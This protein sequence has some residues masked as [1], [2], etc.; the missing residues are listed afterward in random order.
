MSLGRQ[1]IATLGLFLGPALGLVVAVLLP[2]AAAGDQ[3]GLSSAGVATIAVAACMA[4]WWLTQALP[5]AATALLPVAAFPLLGI[6]DIGA[7]TA[8]Y[9]NPLI[10]LF[11]GGFLIGL[12][13]QR[14]G[15]H[16]RI[17]L[18]IL[19]LVGA[20]PR[21]LIGGFMLAAALLSMW[22]SNTAT[23]IMMLPIGASVLKLMEEHRGRGT[24]ASCTPAEMRAFGTA[25]ASGHCLRLLDRRPGDPGRHAPQPGAG[26]LRA[27]ALRPGCQ[28][29]RMAGNRAAAGGRAIAPGLVVPDPDR[30][31]RSRARPSPAAGR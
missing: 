22:I 19:L 20:G 7:S 13:I 29:V 31:R 2:P 11:L 21:A 9:A 24:G 6:A 12:A 3:P 8:P 5:L 4:T 26:R 27:R 18:H 23:A 15:L 14:F 16:R 1:R 28:H 17:A 10:F 25:L 30:L